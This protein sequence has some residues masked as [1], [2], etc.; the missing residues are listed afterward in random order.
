MA[1]WRLKGKKAGRDRGRQ[2]RKKPYW[3]KEVNDFTEEV[4]LEIGSKGRDGTSSLG[5]DTRW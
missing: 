1:Y 5:E 2:E 3:I 4:I